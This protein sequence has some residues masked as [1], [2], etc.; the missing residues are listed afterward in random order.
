MKTKKN[1]LDKFEKT[2]RKA[3]KKEGKARDDVANY[4]SKISTKYGDRWDE[5][6]NSREHAK[7]QS[8]INKKN[9]K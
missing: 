8:L 6:M 4:E 1:N 3:A 9:N 7:Y 5:K 2:F